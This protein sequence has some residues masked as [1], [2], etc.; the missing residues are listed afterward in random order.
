MIINYIR[1]KW[2]MLNRIM[3]IKTKRTHDSLYLE[4]N[5]YENTKEMF[6]FIF[7]NAFPKKIH[8]IQNEDILDIGCAAG[9]FIYFL[10]KN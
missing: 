10:K 1:L 5:R 4:E 9:E 3:T 6:K 2:K 7:K 8:K